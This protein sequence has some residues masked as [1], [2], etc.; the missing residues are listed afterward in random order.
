MVYFNFKASVQIKTP[1]YNVYSGRKEGTLL[2][3]LLFFI[4]SDISVTGMMAALN[5]LPRNE[6][7]NTMN[8]FHSCYNASFLSQ[9][10][11]TRNVHVLR[12]Y[13]VR[14]LLHVSLSL[15]AGF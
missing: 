11:L 6:F 1:A 12:A 14:Q 5:N 2:I 13:W 3:S 10:Y 15:P 7:F 8:F 9:A 4:H